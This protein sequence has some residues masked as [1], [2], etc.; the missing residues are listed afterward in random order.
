MRMI[1]L[2]L[3]F[4]ISLLQNFRK[5]TVSS[6]TDF[7]FR[8]GALEAHSHLN[9]EAHSFANRNMALKISR[10]RLKLQRRKMK[11]TA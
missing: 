10:I 3:L 7:N 2:Q 1:P 4:N 11:F 5:L 9:F 6:E 8:H